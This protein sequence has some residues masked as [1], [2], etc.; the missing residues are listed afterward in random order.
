M[1]KARIGFLDSDIRNTFF[2]MAKKRTGV[3]NWSELAAVLGF[4]ET[5]LTQ[6]RT[7]E[8]LL[9]LESFEQ[10]L[11]FF[12]SHEQHSFR[13]RVFF[14][15]NNWGFGFQARKQ[16]ESRQSEDSEKELLRFAVLAQ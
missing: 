7:G 14:R 15:E 13:L 11:A 8:S 2:A 4:R 12:P 1:F 10:L 5:V 6:I 3:S 9:P 16:K